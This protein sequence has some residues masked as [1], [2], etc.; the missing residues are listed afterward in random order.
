[1]DDM[2]CVRLFHW[3]A[4]EAGPLIAR[5]HA[6]GYDV[7]HHAETQSPSARE[8]KESGAAAVV[9]DLSRM[10][11]HGKY[12]GAWV[13]GSKSTR[14]IPLVF[15]GGEAEKV[16]AIKTHLPDAVYSSVA[17]IAGALKRAIANPPSD[18]VVPRQM[19]ETAPGRTTAQKMGIRAGT[20]V[21]LIDPP[22][23]YLK[24]LGELPE[25]VATEEDSRRVCPVTVWFVHDPGEYEAALPSRRTLAARS[26]LW[27]AWQKGRRDGLNANFVR[28]RALAMGLVDYKICS[29][30][31]VWSGMVFTVKKA[32][33]VSKGR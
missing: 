31:G 12:V 11:S 22:A 5:L 7:V 21:G 6:A 23:D 32:R 26:R 27:I 2:A 28:E 16:A 3:K 30:D 1:M 17:G 9:I 18:P 20:V 15:V 19:M 24:V 8:I 13:R 25:G 10:P 4:K 29:L 33:P 14:H